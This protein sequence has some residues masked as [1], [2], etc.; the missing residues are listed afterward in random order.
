M[1][2][3]ENTADDYTVA[4]LRS[5]QFSGVKFIRYFAL[6]A[7]GTIRCKATPIEVVLAKKTFQNQVSVAAVCIAGLPT[8][9]DMMLIGTGMDAKNVLKL[10]PDMSSLRILPYAPKTAMIMGYAVDQYSNTI[11]PLCSRGLLKRVVEQAAQKHNVAFVSISM[12]RHGCDIPQMG[13]ITSHKIHFFRFLPK[14]VHW[15]RTRVLFN[16]CPNK[17]SGGSF[18]FCQCHH[19]Q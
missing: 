2:P 17:R 16:E 8:Y 7:C 9:A 11:S 19:S 10:Q 6:D 1:S 4:L 13:L 15:C 18:Y 12:S 14:T 5:L 3:L